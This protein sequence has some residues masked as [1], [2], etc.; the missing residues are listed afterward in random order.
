MDWHILL[1]VCSLRCFKD[2]V[3]Q[4]AG[5]RDVLLPKCSIQRLVVYFAVTSVQ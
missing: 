3:M 4:C 1:L 2:L 5:F